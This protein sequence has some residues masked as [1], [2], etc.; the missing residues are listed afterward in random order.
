MKWLPFKS[1]FVL[2]RMCELIKVGIQTDKGFKEGNLTVVA[3][4][5]LQHYGVDVCST[6]V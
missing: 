1:I 6:H 3:K 4:A 2:E 5:L